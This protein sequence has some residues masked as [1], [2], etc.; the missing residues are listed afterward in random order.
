MKKYVDEIVNTIAMIAN[1]QKDLIIAENTVAYWDRGNTSDISGTKLE[2]LCF[3]PWTDNFQFF[4]F[5]WENIDQNLKS[6]QFI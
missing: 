2:W 6:S 5:F 4:K 3:H 1:L